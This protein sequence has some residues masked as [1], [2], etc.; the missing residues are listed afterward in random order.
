MS[1]G[2]GL[3]R[4][5]NQRL[6]VETFRQQIRELHARNTPLLEMVE[7]LG[8]AAEMSPAVRGV[9]AGLSTD[10]VVAIRQAT[11]EMLDRHENR[12]PVDCDLSEA[13]IDN[14]VPVTVTVVDT[15]PARL[16]TVRAATT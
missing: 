13:D 12:M 1:P 2:G 15:A 8:L 5:I 4:L 10:D 11:L 7:T 14:G 3:L 6:P 16:I 9:V